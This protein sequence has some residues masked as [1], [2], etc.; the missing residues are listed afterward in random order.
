M[1][2]DEKN[3]VR[4]LLLFAWGVGV[5]SAH[6]IG[7]RCRLLAGSFLSFLFLLGIPVSVA[8]RSV[9]I[10]DDAACGIELI[11]DSLQLL[12]LIDGHL[13]LRVRRDLGLGE[14][15]IPHVKEFAGLV[16]LPVHVTVIPV[17]A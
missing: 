6:R 3:G 16:E 10:I 5:F 15:G 12:P 13:V 2:G 1:I 8:A 7:L 17:L 9:S 14:G 11:K 4:D